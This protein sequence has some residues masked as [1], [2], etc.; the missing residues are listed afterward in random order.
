MKKRTILTIL[1]VL[2]GAY[3]SWE[4]LEEVR[5]RAGLDRSEKERKEFHKAIA[6]L[7]EKGFVQL[8]EEVLDANG[9]LFG[10]AKITSAG[11]DFYEKEKKD[12]RIW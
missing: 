11:I 7:N 3:P 9:D 6:Y 2:Y 12:V 10:K 4:E 8:D 1:G 5:R